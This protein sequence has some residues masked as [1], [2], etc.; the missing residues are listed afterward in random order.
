MNTTLKSTERR[1]RFNGFR[2]L[3]CGALLAVLVAAC[4]YL[5]HTAFTFFHERMLEQE[6]KTIAWFVKEIGFALP[7]IVICLFHAMVYHKHDRRDGDAQREM[8]WEIMVVAVLTFGVLLP[9]LCD[10]SDQM[11]EASLAANA[12]IPETEGNVDW[13]LIM[14]LHEWF[15]RLTIPLSIL[16]IFHGSRARRERVRPDAQPIPETVE[17]Y[18]ARMTATEPA[19]RVSVE[20]EEATV[21]AEGTAPVHAVE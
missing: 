14:K 13:T 7:F 11:H 5:H 20:G 9:Y 21:E 17:A 10:L 18:K 3:F 16:M 8:F 19:V 4:L 12:I 2:V 1:Y 15:I 6:K